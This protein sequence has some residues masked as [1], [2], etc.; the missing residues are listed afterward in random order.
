VDLLFNAQA[1]PLQA[2]SLAVL[3]VFWTV[4]HLLSIQLSVPAAIMEGV[5]LAC[6]MLYL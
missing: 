3:P 2:L 6:A 5:L 4:P 1:L